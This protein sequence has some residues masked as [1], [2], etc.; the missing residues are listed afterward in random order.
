MIAV[1]KK[2][3][4]EKVTLTEQEWTL[5]QSVC[6]ERKLRKQ[7]YLLQ[8]GDVWHYNAFITKGCLRRYR[9]DDKGVEH[10]LQFSV[11]N[12][13]AG[14][15]DSLINGTPSKYS[16]D[17]IEDSVVILIRKEDFDMLV[18]RIPEFRN[19]VNIILE[20]SLIASQERIH[21]AISLTAEEKYL[22]FVERYPGLS[23]RVPRRM[24]ASYLGVTPETL[25]RVRQVVMKK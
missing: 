25:S 3:I 10:I 1:F 15:R 8:E 18:N 6:I 21:D 9:I 2:Y 5:I 20:K 23:N 19:L 22:G 7:Q 12:W 11:E 14:D 4:T 16:I 24:L 13:W 17:A